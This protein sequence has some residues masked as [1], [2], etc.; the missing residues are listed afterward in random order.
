MGKSKRIFWGFLSLDYKAIEEY[1]EEMASKGWMLEKVGRWSAQFRS[2]EAKKLKFYVDIF[3]DGGP[4]SPENTEEAEEYRNLCKESGWNFITSRDYLQFFYAEEDTNP[5]PIQTDDALEQEIVKSTL[6]KTEL[7]SLIILIAFSIKITTLYLPTEYRYLLS[8]VGVAGILF[9]LLTISVASPVIYSLIR[10]VK[11]RKDLS[12]GLPIEK[13]TLAS[14]RKRM[15]LLHYITIA[16]AIIFIFAFAIDTFF[17]PEVVS[18]SLSGPLIGIIIGLITRFFIKKKSKDKKDSV[19][20]VTFAILGVLF[21]VAITNSIFSHIGSSP[22]YKKATIPQGYPIITMSD[23][24]EDSAQGILVSSE[25]NRGMSPIVAKHFSY[26]EL[27]DDGGKRDS[28]YIKYY[29]CI[30]PYFAEM[31]FNGIVAELKEGIKYKGMR[32]FQR[33]LI[34]DEEMKNLWDVDN[35]VLTKERDELIVQKGNIV[36]NLTASFDLEDSRVREVTI[37]KFF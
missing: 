8:F 31:I 6:W 21:I 11:A 24:S 13:P 5:T 3:K 37:D 12:R 28:I 23:L 35:F 34:Y 15:I 25:F 4:F 19:L 18:I 26:S 27:W 16:I 1:L 36:V 33:A 17:R 2:M 22:S 32:L 7:I 30:N 9:P 14:A 20:Y 29:K 10:T